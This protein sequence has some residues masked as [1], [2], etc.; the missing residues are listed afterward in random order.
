MLTGKRDRNR[1]CFVKKQLLLAVLV[2]SW[3]LPPAVRA[4]I[5]MYEDKDGVRHYTNAP[6]SSR[7][8][9]VRLGG[10]NSRSRW[11]PGSAGSRHMGRSRANPAAYDSHIRRAAS[12]N[13]VDPLLIK[14]I[15]KAESN[16]NRYAVSA[17][18]AQGLMQLMPGTARD[19]RVGNPFDPGQ[20]INGGTRYFKNLL[21]TYQGDLA[22]SLAAYNAGPG[23]VAKNGPLPQIRETREYVRRVLKHYRSY[24][25]NSRTGGP[26]RIKARKLVTVN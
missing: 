22:L 17:K 5:Y 10:F 20:N 24:Q 18:G 26:G 16:F 14:A 4:Q 23:R 8:K 21:N 6:T 13:R 3:L 2:L 25:Q 19:L 9:P 12:V 11:T 1:E 15:I 7:Y